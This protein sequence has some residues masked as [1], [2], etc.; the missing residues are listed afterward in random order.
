MPVFMETAI[1]IPC[2]E[3]VQIV[4]LLERINPFIQCFMGIRLTYQD[5]IKAL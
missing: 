4:A 1:P 2:G 3:I 5:K